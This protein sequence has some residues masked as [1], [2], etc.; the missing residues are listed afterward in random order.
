MHPP[1]SQSPSGQP[2]QGP[3]P[4]GGPQG[5]PPMQVC[6][7]KVVHKKQFFKRSSVNVN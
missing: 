1:Q 4:P 3:M 7:V 5:G 2:P 6:T